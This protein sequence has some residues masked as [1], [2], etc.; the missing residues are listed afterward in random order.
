[1]DA[2]ITIQ[3]INRFV[4][5]RKTLT[6]EVMTLPNALNGKTARNSFP[7]LAALSRRA[8]SL[9]LKCAGALFPDRGHW[10]LEDASSTLHCHISVKSSALF[11]NLVR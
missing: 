7:T 2:L 8:K 3:P 11:E 10:V 1:M 6:G 9:A 5:I 4:S